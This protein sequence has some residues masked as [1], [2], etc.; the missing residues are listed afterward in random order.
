MK[1]KSKSVC[2]GIVLIAA[3]VTA[4]AAQSGDFTYESSGTEITITRYTGPGGDVL[5]PDTIAGLPVTRIGAWAFSILTDVTSVAIGK[6]VTSIDQGG[7]YGCTAL[8]SITVDAMNPVYSS[9]GGVVFN[10]NRDTLMLC[11]YGRSGSYAIPP[12]V[13]SIGESAFGG[14][15]GLSSVT[16]GNGVTSIEG[17]AFRYC[18]GLTSVT[19]PS[20]VTNI[21]T[22]A[23]E[24]CTGLESIDVDALNATYSSVG[25]VVFSKNRDTLMLCPY[26]RSGSYAIPPGVTS[27]ADS[28]FSG[29]PS[30]TNVT[31]GSGVT[32][33]GAAAFWDCSALSTVTIPNGVASIG[34]SAFYG[35]SSLTAV[36]IPDSVTGIGDGTFVGCIS[37]TNAAIGN[38]VGRIGLEAFFGCISLTE[39][40]IPNSVTNIDGWWPDKFAYSNGRGAFEASGLNRITIPNSVTRIGAGAFSRCSSLMNISIPNSV[41]SIEPGAFY[42]CTSLTTVNIPGGVTTIERR[43]FKYCSGLTNVTIPA[44]LRSIND[45]WNGSW[46]SPDGAFQFCSSLVTVTISDGLEAIGSYTFLGCTSLASVEIPKSVTSIGNAAFADCTSLN[47][48]TVDPL[49][50]NYLSL[51]GVLFNQSRTDL[52]QYPGGRAGGHYDIPNT[53]TSIWGSAFSRCPRLTSVSIPDSVTGIGSSAFSSCTSLTNVTIGSGVTKIDESAFSGCT[54]LRNV[55]IPDSVAIVVS[56][57]FSGCTSL[58]NVTIG[59]GITSIEGGAFR[60]CTGLITVTI[61]SGVINIRDNAFWGCSSLTGVYFR[62]NAPSLDPDVFSGANNAI[63]YYLPTATGWGSTFGG[64]PTALWIDPPVYSEWLPF[65]GLPTQYPD[66]SAEADDPDQDGM[67]NYAEMLAG[68]DPTDRASLLILERV[69]RPADLTEADRTPIAAGQHAL[70]FR[71]VPG[72]R[73]G[74]QWADAVDGP[75]STTAVVI[76]ATTQKRLVFDKPATHAFYRVILAQ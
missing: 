1:T 46:G 3:S 67:S 38:S 19:I 74:V 16:I 14:C 29:C 44:S 63:V 10:K 70:Y 4:H 52:M 15:S 12:G 9:V 37:L 36:S 33:I 54:S 34:D 65:S 30:L 71:S 22:S 73:Y 40:T 25:G 49:N 26:G 20:G 59:N 31:I 72:K 55:T 39:I 56:S 76:P 51:D 64:R 24:Y 7:F 42:A 17:G 35:C 8:T 60:Y 27:I 28:A 48:I 41:T 69:P 62:G 53:V 50:P 6:S 68:T 57:A 43:T 5:I 23:F 47:A 61:G 75:W 18:T 11:P 2:F 13:T 32:N 66:A 58:T 21:V 45:G